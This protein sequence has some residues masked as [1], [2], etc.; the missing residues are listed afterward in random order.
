VIDARALGAIEYDEYSVVVHALNAAR[1]VLLRPDLETE[2]PA[3]P[4]QLR[5]L[6]DDMNRGG[7]P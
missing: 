5:A 2:Q 7:R 4:E 1:R 6:A 3:T